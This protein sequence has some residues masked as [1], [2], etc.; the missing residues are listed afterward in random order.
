MLEMIEGDIEED[1]RNEVEK[2]GSFRGNFRYILDVFRF[3]K[4][5][6]MKRFSIKPDSVMGMNINYLKVAIR[7]TKRDKTNSILSMASL[8]VALI[9]SMVIY[10][11]VE[12]HL[13]FDAFHENSDRIYR[14]SYEEIFNPDSDR[15]MATVGP[16]LGP[17]IKEFYPEVANS[18]RFR[19]SPSQVVSYGDKNFYEDKIFYADPSILEVFSFP[20][21]FG[22]INTALNEKNSIILTKEMALKY[23]EK[24]NPIGNLI[25][26]ENESLMVTGVF[27]KIPSNNHLHFDF[28]RPFDAFEVPYGYPVTL[29]DWGW[30]SFHTYVLLEPGANA[31]ELENKLPVFAKTHFDEERLAKFRYRLQPITDIYFGE[32]KDDDVASG[33]ISYVLVLISVGFLLLIL[34]IFN[35]TNIATAKSL[36]RSTETGIRKALGSSLQGLWWRYLIEPII[37]ALSA[38]LIAIL[39]VPLSLDYINT[40][41]G[42][43]EIAND[44]II[45]KLMLIFIPLGLLIGI[46]AGFYPAFIMSSFR[47]VSVLKGKMRVDASGKLLRKSLITLQFMITSGLLIG[48]FLIKAQMN[49]MLNKDLGYDKDE[50]ALVHMPGEVLERY[51]NP[52][53]NAFMSNP[54]VLNVSIAGGRMDG[55]TGSGPITVD[56]LDEPI[57]MDI[58]AVG[59]DFF[60]TIGVPVVS[61]REFSSKIPYDSADGVILNMNAVKTLGWSPDE[62][63]GQH[64]IVSGQRDGHVMGVVENFHFRTL[65]DEIKPLVMIY[66]HTRLREM[67][68]KV[69]PGNVYDVVTSIER[70]WKEAVPDVPFDFTFL[71]DHLQSLYKA[72]MQFAS[73]VKTFSWITIV[74]ATLGLYGLIALICKYRMKEVGV[75]KVLGASI[76][77]VI[78]TLSKSFVL[79]IV[80]ANLI[81]W[82]IVYIIARNWIN[83]F[84][85][86]VDLNPIY[87]VS[88]T[89]I[90]L[91]IA[92][93]TLV[94]QTG[95]SA[96]IN[97]AM[98]LKYE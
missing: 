48:S 1:F 71:N 18:V 54:N 67:Y 50:I 8:I 13:T 89:A 7:G 81:A 56:G 15:K 40:F 29:E 53:K 46:L 9:C 19:Y 30:I 72:D 87:F 44:Q 94:I 88:G 61:G 31:M 20:L 36:T 85:Y 58:N 10:S 75:R 14:V 35:F 64:I 4:P 17:G 32:F 63:L 62:A 70:D 42:I 80:V 55:D 34:S 90:T 78:Y 96:V 51:Y 65:H 41:L 21:M 86:Q 66:P 57:P 33:D 91:L 26:V 43:G 37:L 52:L 28:I 6:A 74:V 2:R 69:K 22:D 92:T 60:K 23:F 11:V 73:L 68:L 25:E 93:L 84:A 3:F 83:S 95:K 5:F 82:P 12:N 76:N 59:E 27:D 24:A 79:I 98:I 97:P 45:W 47:P 77:S 38:V 39:L 16:P 49:F